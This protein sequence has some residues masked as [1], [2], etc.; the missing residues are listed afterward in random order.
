MPWKNGLGT[1]KELYKN[2]LN[3]KNK[4]FDYD[5]RLSIATL[6]TPTPFSLFPEYKRIILLQEGHGFILRK[7]L[8]SSSQNIII[9]NFHLYHEFSGTEKIDVELIDGPCLDFNIFWNPQALNVKIA[10]QI[11]NLESIKSCSDYLFVFNRQTMELSLSDK[12]EQ[13]LLESLHER[14]KQ[15]LIFIGA[16]LQ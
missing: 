3:Q 15:S 1:T 9:D 6:S 5:F 7:N 4:K 10:T 16:V 11:E 12:E 8:V 14:Q 2:H 13:S